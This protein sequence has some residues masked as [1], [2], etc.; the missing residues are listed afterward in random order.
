MFVALLQIVACKQYIFNV[1]KSKSEAAANRILQEGTTHTSYGV[2][3]I[4]THD[5][6]ANKQKIDASAYS[7]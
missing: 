3:K 6:D 4:S 5:T 2:Y 1:E 7:F